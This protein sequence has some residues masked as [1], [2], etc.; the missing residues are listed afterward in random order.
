MTTC[1]YDSG[2]ATNCQP[3]CHQPAVIQV[4]EHASGGYGPFTYPLCRRHLSPML[5]RIHPMPN[6]TIP[7][8]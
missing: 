7:V 6:H 1:V 5:G 8:T 2:S 3:L 4:V